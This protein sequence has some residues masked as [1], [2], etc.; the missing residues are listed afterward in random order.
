M[1][2][3]GLRIKKSGRAKVVRSGL[4]GPCMRDGGWIIKQTEREGLFTLME[5][6]MT[7]NGLMIKLM[8]SV[9]TVT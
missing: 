5:M 8:D 7:V 3:N 6:S 9:C 2:E 1:R 4:T